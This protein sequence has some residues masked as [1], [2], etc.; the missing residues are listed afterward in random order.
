MV[1][2][3]VQPYSLFFSVPAG[4]MYF[5]H[6]YNDRYGGLVILAVLFLIAVAV[7]VAL[8]AALTLVHQM[9]SP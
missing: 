2:W 3:L 1:L 4:V 9:M 8:I 6:R 7:L 5:A